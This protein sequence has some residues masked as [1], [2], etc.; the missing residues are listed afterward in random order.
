[1]ASLSESKAMSASSMVAGTIGFI[2]PEQFLHRIVLSSSD[3][4]SL[5]VTI[6]CLLT[7]TKTEE[8]NKL[9]DSRYQFKLSE[10]RE[11]VSR[12]WLAWHKKLVESEANER[13]KD[14]ATALEQLK[15]LNIE[16][17]SSSSIITVEYEE[18]VKS[19]EENFLIAFLV[20]ILFLCYALVFGGIMLDLPVFLRDI[21]P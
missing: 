3:L 16:P 14:A 4:Y 15:A 19:S 6:Y 9:I 1:M 18:E 12:E 11:K 20:V 8:V 2:A 5:G 17:Q 13:I 21:Y 7:N 10:L